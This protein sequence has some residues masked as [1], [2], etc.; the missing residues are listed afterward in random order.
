M[1]QNYID[2]AFIGLYIYETKS[3]LAIKFIVDNISIRFNYEFYT[4]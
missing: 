2:V 1:I 4:I 3:K